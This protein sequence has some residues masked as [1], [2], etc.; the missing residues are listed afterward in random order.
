[1]QRRPDLVVDVRDT[2]LKLDLNPEKITLL[3]RSALIEDASNASERLGA[4]YAEINVHEDNDV[5]IT[6]DEDLWPEGKDPVSALAVAALLGI[7]VEQE[8]CLRELPFAWPALGEH[9]FSTVE[10]TEIMLKAYADQRADKPI[11]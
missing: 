5:W 6:F 1:M 9:T 8:V 2:R 4:L 3:I 11:E 7:R 10:Y